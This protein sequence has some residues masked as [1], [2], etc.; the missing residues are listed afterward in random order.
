MADEYIANLNI[1]RQPILDKIGRELSLTGHYIIE[2]CVQD[3]LALRFSNRD[4]RPDWPEDFTLNYDGQA[5]FLTVHAAS[6]QERDKLIQDVESV[7]KFYGILTSFE[8]V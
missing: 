6:K 2:R 1:G 8:T 5:L 3:E 4:R 7:L